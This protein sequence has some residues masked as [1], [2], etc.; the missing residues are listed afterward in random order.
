MSYVDTPEKRMEVAQKSYIFK[1]LD[2]DELRA[3]AQIMVPAQFAAQE[4]IMKEGEMGQSMYL[5]AS[6][7]VQVN[8]ALTM[9]FGEDDFRETE[10]ILTVLKADHGVVFGEMALAT[11]SER[12]ATIT[13]MTDCQLYRI[14]REDFLRLGHERPALGF[15]ATLRIA[16]LVS[17]RLKKSGDDVIR[18]TTA[19]SIALS[20]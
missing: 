10:K 8:K 16:E 20:P 9:K 15:K 6:G 19:L 3:V 5:M 13:A 18:L 2:Q 11:D 12:S 1:D 4:V 7:D 17:Q 14:R